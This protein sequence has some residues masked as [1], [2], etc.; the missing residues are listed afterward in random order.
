MLPVQLASPPALPLVEGPR[1][2]AAVVLQGVLGLQLPPTVWAHQQLALSAAQAA[3][4]A[5][6]ALP[7]PAAQ[8]QGQ[9]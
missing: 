7:L 4:A 6:S 5:Q 9:R 8:Q 2:A 1:L 3:R